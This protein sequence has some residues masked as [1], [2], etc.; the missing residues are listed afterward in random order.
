M[1][2]YQNEE[3]ILDMPENSLNLNIP[4]AFFIDQASLNWNELYFGLKSQYVSLN[5]AIEKAVSEVSIN[6]NTSYTLFELASLFKNEEDLAEKYINDL[7]QEKII[8]SMLLENKQF[9]IDCKNKYLY[10]ALLWLYQNPK[11]YNHPKRY[12]S[13][14]KEIDY[15]TKVYNVIWDFKIPSIPARDFRYFSMTFEVTEKNQELFLNRWN[16]FLEEQKQIVE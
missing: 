16:Q 13:E 15:S 12:D 6:D 9:M 14:L 11:K 10:I 5:Y 3:F 7:I 4:Y 8:D 2:D 1:T